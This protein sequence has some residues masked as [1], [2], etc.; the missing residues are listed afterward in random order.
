MTARYLSNLAAVLSPE[1][2]IPAA[3]GGTGNTSGGGSSGPKISLVT[4]TDSSYN[5]LDD[6]AVNVT[7][8][9][10]KITGSGF[11]SGCQVLVN[12]TAATSVTF[13]SA[14]EVR[15]QL[16]ATAAGTYIL[17][18]VNT[19]G[20]TAIRVN[21][22]TF[23]ATPT[24]TTESPLA[25]VIN[26]VISIQL[27]ATNATTFSVA[28]GSSLPSGVSLSSSGL[29][30]GTVTGIS[31]NT[32]YNFTVLATDAE[33]QESPKTFAFTIDASDPYFMYTT[34]L[35]SGNGTNNAQNNTFLDSSTNNFAITR[36]GNTTQG[37]FSPYGP[38]WSN[39]FDG[40]GDYLT[41]P[42]NA[43]FNFG[44]GD[45][46]VE[47]WVYVISFTGSTNVI[48][49]T[50]QNGSNGW[51]IGIVS[52]VFYGSVAGDSVEIYSS[53]TPQVNTWTH[54]ALTRS[55]TT[56]SLFVNGVVAA[57]QS[58]STN[59]STTS[60][61][62]IGTNVG[63]GAL[64]F[65]G[66]ISN[67]RI[68]KGTALYTTTFT[69]NTTPLTAIANTSLL[70]CQSN[71]L[72]DNSTNNFTITKN[73]DVSVQRFSPSSP[74]AAYNT[75]II[76]GSGYFDGD[77][78]L[79]VPDNAA[80]ALGSSNFTMEAWIYPTATGSYPVIAAQY[81]TGN[82]SFFWSLGISSAPRDASFFLYSSSGST[83]LSAS[84]VIVLNTWAH[85]AVVRNSNTLTYYINGVSIATASFSDTVNDSSSVITIGNAG[86]TN[87]TSY[88]FTGY[89]SN[90]RIVKGTAV[91]TAAFTPPTSPVTAITNTSLLL[92]YTNA[93]I[94][95]NTMLNN[96]ET[97]GNAKISTTQSKF[98]SS[99]LYFDGTG[100]YLKTPT[101]SRNNFNFR[102]GNFTIE[103]W[104]YITAA[105]QYD[106]I[107]GTN[108]SGASTG[109]QII[110]DYPTAGAWNL[111]FQMSSDTYGFS[112]GSI[113]LNNWVHIAATRSGTTVR[114]FVNGSQITSST[115]GGGSD[116]NEATGTLHIGQGAEVIAGRDFNGYIDDIRITKGY[117]RYTA[118]FTPPTVTATPQ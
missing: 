90:L 117:A 45:F 8:G 14:T 68:V 107:M 77:D 54:L 85:H 35:L 92:N 28:G 30:T 1:G 21:G 109:W 118:N 50:Y 99:S 108:A 96:L 71:R 62:T 16:P 88:P 100:D 104:V 27:A 3:K 63:G 19:D 7:G 48:I 18:V 25:G 6:T 86:E 67:F 9:Y 115:T 66:Y 79:S 46:T 4:V 5:V 52:N 80:F 101:T 56:L 23:S 29:L 24:W 10:I 116:I 57:T 93:S 59:M 82:N 73:G 17:Y 111:T 51:T 74:P 114:T 106:L 70:T 110:Y 61:L 47:C 60:A 95:D 44:T 37:T 84:N 64:N 33:L 15:A 91:Y 69:P 22:I 38:N 43:A 76:G 72:I 105:G 32:T 12:N 55:S 11:A 49:S 113:S 26:S 102:K 42:N 65:T 78:Y 103:A 89:I 75:S 39:Y 97:V 40:T 94:I 58:N 98:G 36:A 87:Y 53:V 83:V 31:G 81:Q 20:G 2:I 13:I 112:F 34:L 41:A